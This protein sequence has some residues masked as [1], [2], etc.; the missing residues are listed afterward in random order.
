M[1]NRSSKQCDPK[2]L[3]H[4]EAPLKQIINPPHQ[5]THSQVYSNHKSRYPAQK[6]A[7]GKLLSLTEKG[8]KFHWLFIANNPASNRRLHPA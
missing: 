2:P 8:E 6:W 1:I 7:E 3:S 5:I 4:E